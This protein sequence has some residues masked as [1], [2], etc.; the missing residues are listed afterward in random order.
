MEPWWNGW[1]SETKEPH[2]S[3]LTWNASAAQVALGRWV[4][5][6]ETGIFWLKTLIIQYVKI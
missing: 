5:R 2:F 4:V 6:S 3:A 1:A